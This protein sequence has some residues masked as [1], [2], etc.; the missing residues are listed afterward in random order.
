MLTIQAAFYAAY[1]VRLRPECQ[2]VHRAAPFAV[3]AGY[4]AQCTALPCSDY[5]ESV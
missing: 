1:L 4:G 3:P 5:Y 2:R